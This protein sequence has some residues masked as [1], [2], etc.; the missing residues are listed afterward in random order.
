[1]KYIGRRR[2]RH[3]QVSCA[4]SIFDS[5]VRKEGLELVCFALWVDYQVLPLD[6]NSFSKLKEIF[7][8]LRVDPYVEGKSY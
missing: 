7:Y 4:K 5:Q 3:Y 6:I 2:R 1:M 8:V